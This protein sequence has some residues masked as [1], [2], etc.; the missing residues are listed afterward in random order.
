MRKTADWTKG[1]SLLSFT[2]GRERLVGKPQF[3]YWV[4]VPGPLEGKSLFQTHCSLVC[5][6]SSTQTKYVCVCEN[7]YLNIPHPK[8]RKPC[9]Y[10]S[11]RGKGREG[12]A[13][14]WHRTGQKERR[15]GEDRKISL[16][17]SCCHDNPPGNTYSLCH[18]GM[19]ESDELSPLHSPHKNTHS[20]CNPLCQ[21]ILNSIE[22]AKQ[23]HS[24]NKLK[25]YEFCLIR[26]KSWNSN[27]SRAELPYLLSQSTILTPTA[28][29]V[30]IGVFSEQFSSRTRKRKIDFYSGIT[31][32]LHCAT[33]PP[34]FWQI[35]TIS[36][37][38]GFEPTI[39]LKER[40]VHSDCFLVIS[41]PNLDIN[42]GLGTA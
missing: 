8:L 27:S 10:K 24:Q 33:V 1:V 17:C 13:E 34:H 18:S 41:G 11:G 2:G 16:H 40:V 19:K 12:E 15:R 25:P 21:G 23:T 7:A 26:I 38:T 42:N 31:P 35:S 3:T 22:R 37:P 9:L 36:M 30:W 5:Y 6:T 20:V 14:I 32:R 28:L 39:I 4:E 29:I